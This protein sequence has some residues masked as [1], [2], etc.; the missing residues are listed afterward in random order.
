MFNGSGHLELFLRFAISIPHLFHTQCFENR[1]LRTAVENQAKSPDQVGG[2]TAQVCR[3]GD[4]QQ[5]FFSTAVQT[6]LMGIGQFLRLD[7]RSCNGELSQNR[8]TAQK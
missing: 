8:S 7:Q 6:D 1:V 2:Y 3:T 5:N 4:G